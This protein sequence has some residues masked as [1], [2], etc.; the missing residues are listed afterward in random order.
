MTSIQFYIQRWLTLRWLRKVIKYY[1]FVPERVKNL[2]KF[3]GSL[4]STN[5]LKRTLLRLGYVLQ[6]GQTRDGFNMDT[7]F[8]NLMEEN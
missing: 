3:K 8:I 7:L 1:E 4:T 2:N 6:E 5:Y